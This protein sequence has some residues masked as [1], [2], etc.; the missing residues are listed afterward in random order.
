M[1]A[2][3][4]TTKAAKQTPAKASKVQPART[5]QAD[6]RVRAGKLSALDAA[7]KVLCDAKQP[8]NCKAMIEAM[9]TK[10]YWKSPAG[11]TPQ[12]NCLPLVAISLRIEAVPLRQGRPRPYRTPCLADKSQ[13]SP[14][15]CK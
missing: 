14:M 5:V 8:M 12:A 10:G 1:P 4:A 9:A 13:S 11:K 3:K 7:A 15:P 6:A 2:K